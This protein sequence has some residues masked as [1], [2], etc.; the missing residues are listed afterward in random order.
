MFL[1]RSGLTGTIR[2]K[3]DFGKR[4]SKIE[5]E[6]T[7]ASQAAELDKFAQDLIDIPPP[8]DWTGDF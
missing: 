7:S 6:K 4:L 8:P 5:A 1:G 3:N 2:A